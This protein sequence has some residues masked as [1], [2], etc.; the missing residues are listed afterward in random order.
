MNFYLKIFNRGSFRS[1]IL[2][3]YYYSERQ[4]FSEF[5]RNVI[6]I[7]RR[8]NFR[9]IWG[10]SKEVTIV[11]YCSKLSSGIEPFDFAVNFINF[12]SY[13]PSGAID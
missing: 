10:V 1:F 12:Y 7:S 11:I 5:I 4:E 9:I 13:L 6:S 2:N 8:G 3:N